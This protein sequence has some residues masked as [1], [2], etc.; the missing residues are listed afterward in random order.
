MSDTEQK[1]SLRIALDA[2][3]G[4]FAPASEVQGAVKL[5]D[6]VQMQNMLEI[7]FVGDETKIKNA[8]AKSDTS[9]I[10]YSIVHADDVIT[11]D[12]EPTHALKKKKNSSIYIGTELLAQQKVDAFCSAGNTGAMLA[13][14][15]LLLGRIN[16]VSRPTIG[17]FFPNPKEHPTLLLDVGAN[18]EVKAKYLYEF[19]VMGSIYA[20]YMQ[21]IPQPRVGLM[22]IGEEESKGTEVL[23]Q[24]YQMLKESNLNFIGNVEGRDILNGECDVVI[25]DGFTGNIILKFAESVYGLIKTK[26]KQYAKKGFLNKLALMMSAPAMKSVFKDFDYQQYGGVPVLGVNGVVIIGHG[27]STPMAIQNM[28]LR[29]VEQVKQE[30]NKKIEIALNP[31]VINNKV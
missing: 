12:D 13:A 18:I 1:K 19:A 25:C 28:L 14:S 7:V 2:M 10:R 17:S 26:F 20:N 5:F 30:I 22:N 3:G 6:N 31:N 15:T 23:H 9:K 11:M 27:K 8:L 21:G 4:D 29:A 16:G 24:T